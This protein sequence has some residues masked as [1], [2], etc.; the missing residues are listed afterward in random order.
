VSKMSTLLR[1]SLTQASVACFLF[2][3]AALAETAWVP[4]ESLLASGHS[5][6]EILPEDVKKCFANFDSG[7]FTTSETAISRYG[8]EWTWGQSGAVICTRQVISDDVPTCIVR[9]PSKDLFPKDSPKEWI[10]YLDKGFEVDLSDGGEGH[11]FYTIDINI[12]PHVGVDWHERTTQE[13]WRVRDQFIKHYGV[14][15]PPRAL[16]VFHVLEKMCRRDMS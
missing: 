8:T 12:E 1:D 13:I 3:N 2:T 7:N 9:T 11:R 5:V 15:L 10:W 14:P 4:P 16:D 6:D